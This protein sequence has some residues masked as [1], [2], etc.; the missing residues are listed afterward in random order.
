MDSEDPLLST[1]RQKNSCCQLLKILLL[2]N[3][4]RTN[5]HKYT[6]PI[7]YYNPVLSWALKQ[8]HLDVSIATKIEQL[9]KLANKFDLSN[10]E[11]FEGRYETQTGHHKFWTRWYVLNFQEGS[12]MYFLFLCLKLSLSPI[13][14][15]CS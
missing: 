7:T 15:W 6:H 10:I 14:M 13:S 5:S 4:S 2:P 1:N 3:T 12:P 11:S 9:S 8:H